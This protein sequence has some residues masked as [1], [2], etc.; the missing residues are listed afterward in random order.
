MNEVID[1]LLDESEPAA[2]YRTLTWLLGQKETDKDV[3]KARERLA[4]D[5]SVKRIFAM[6]DAD[7]G[8]YGKGCLDPL[9]PLCDFGVAGS[10]PRIRKALDLIASRQTQDGGFKHYYGKKLPCAA[11]YATGLLLGF[12]EENDKRTQD[13]ISH[14]L[15]IQ[16]LDGGW[17]HGLNTLPG[18]ARENAESCPHATL[19]VLWMVSMNEGLRNSKAA[20]RA[21]DCVLRHWVTRVPD[22]AHGFGIGSR[23]SNLKYPLAGYHSLAYASILARFPA[24]CKDKRLR[25]V[26]LAILAKK[27]D[28]GRFKAESVFQHFSEFEFSRKNQPSKWITLH[29]L[30]TIKRVLGEKYS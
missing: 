8:F 5:P 17:L 27:G 19:H 16:R 15:S 9:V 7:G 20:A 4:E 25:E 24:A 3:R 13:G 6:Q 22:K 11:A 2:R 18:G 26:A 28:D 12:G 21:L 23:F 1:W 10:D 30:W 29:S 14:L